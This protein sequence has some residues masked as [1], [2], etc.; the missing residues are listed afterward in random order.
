MK[1]NKDRQQLDCNRSRAAQYFCKNYSREQRYLI[2][3]SRDLKKEFEAISRLG[4][5]KAKDFQFFYDYILDFE[6]L[7]ELM[8]E[9][10]WSPDFLRTNGINF[11]KL[12]KLYFAVN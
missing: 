6:K 1:T 12:R 8:T 4:I 11:Q 7:R 5:E 10:R 3:L 9:F 2:V